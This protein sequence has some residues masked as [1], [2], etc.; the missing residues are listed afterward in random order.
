[1][2]TTY[3]IAVQMTADGKIPIP[4]EVRQA[5]GLAPLQTVYLH[6]GPKGLV[7]QRMSRQEIVNRIRELMRACFAEFSD[8]ELLQGRVDDEY[9]L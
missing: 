1:M 8:D 3:P 4:V 2:Q 5:L 6:L 7:I 9:R